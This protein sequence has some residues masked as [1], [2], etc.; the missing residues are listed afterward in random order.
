ML[1]ESNVLSWLRYTGII[2]VELRNL[3]RGAS[4]SLF[5]FTT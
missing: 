2:A 1:G 3:E 5:F 4:A